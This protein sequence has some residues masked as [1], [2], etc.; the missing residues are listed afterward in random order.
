[1]SLVW[2]SPKQRDNVHFFNKNVRK[3]GGFPRQCAHR[4][5]MKPHFRQSE[6]PCGISAGVFPWGAGQAGAVTFFCMTYFYVLCVTSVIS[7]DT[8]PPEATALFSVLIKHR[9]FYPVGA[10]LQP[11]AEGA[12]SFL[13]YTFLFAP[14]LIDLIQLL[15]GDGAILFKRNSLLDKNTDGV[16]V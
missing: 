16:V 11:I 4:L 1:M 13:N 14:C 6:N 7:F 3:T 2:Q 9:G 10:M 12:H 15:G 8:D 5:G